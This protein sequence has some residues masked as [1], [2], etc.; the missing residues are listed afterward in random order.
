M[1]D[2]RPRGGQ[3]TAGLAFVVAWCLALTSTGA[4]GHPE[5]APSLRDRLRRLAEAS[6]ED[7]CLTPAIDGVFTQA[8][9]S[10]AFRVAL[11][12]SF[13]ITDVSSRDR[14]I[15]L[16]VAKSGGRANTV[17]LALERIV[18]RTPDGRAGEFVFYVQPD[19]DAESSGVLLELARVLAG[20]VPATAF[21]P[22]G[23][24]DEAVGTRAVALL[25]AAVEVLVVIVALTFGWRTLGRR[26]AA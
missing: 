20:R 3:R 6:L 9:E 19:A 22:C 13:A 10:G 16:T 5:T 25:S 11:G 1:S 4:A 14:R 7:R 12:R 17:T 26:P 18:G 15:E 2:R 8:M 21:A 23:G 24:R